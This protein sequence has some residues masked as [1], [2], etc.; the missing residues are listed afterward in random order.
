MPAA[1][2]VRCAHGECSLCSRWMPAARE[3][4]VAAGLTFFDFMIRKA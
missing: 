3:G 2:N 1:V 4:G